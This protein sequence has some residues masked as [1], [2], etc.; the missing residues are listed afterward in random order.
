MKAASLPTPPIQVDVSEY[1]NEEPTKYNPGYFAEMPRKV[2]GYPLDA[3]AP[4]R[5]IQE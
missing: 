1:W 5:S 4:G 3:I 2:S